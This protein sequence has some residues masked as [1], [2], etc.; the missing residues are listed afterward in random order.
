MKALKQN[1]LI[2]LTLLL[3]LLSV[4]FPTW[5]ENVVLCYA[6]DNHVKVEV[7]TE[8][9]CRTPLAIPYSKEN[10]YSQ[11]NTIFSKDCCGT[12]FDIPI[13]KNHVADTFHI[14]NYTASHKPN[15]YYDLHS[16]I[17]T[18]PENNLLNPSSLPFKIHHSPSLQKSL[19]TVVLLI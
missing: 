16:I 13:S 9:T 17:Q 12:C 3:S 18:F 14:Y 4:P 8:Q 1:Y 15:F 2:W 19:R 7:I 11:F 6:K 10:I 5:G